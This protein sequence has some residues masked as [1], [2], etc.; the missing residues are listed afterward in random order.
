M[1]CRKHERHVIL[2]D[3]EVPRA[4]KNLLLCFNT[5]ITTAMKSKVR[6]SSIVQLF[7]YD[8]DLVRLP[9]PIELNT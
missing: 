7:L 5:S 8:F 9:N 1:L 2:K 3:P 4:S 6:F